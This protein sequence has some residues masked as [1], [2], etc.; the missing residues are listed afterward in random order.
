MSVI[1]IIIVIVMIIIM[2]VIGWFYIYR[3]QP[4]PL[5]PLEEDDTTTPSEIMNVLMQRRGFESIR[6]SEP[7][8]QLK[9]GSTGAF[10]PYTNK[11][12]EHD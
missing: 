9:H 6:M 10:I 1:V 3:R 2:A 5:Q 4:K 12:D 11:D 7:F 8:A